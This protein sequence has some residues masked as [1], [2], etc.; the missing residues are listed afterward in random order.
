MS[1][2]PDRRLQGLGWP[3]KVKGSHFEVVETGARSVEGS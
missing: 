1:I 3:Q 2:A